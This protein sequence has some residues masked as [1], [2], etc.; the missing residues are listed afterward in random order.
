VWWTGLAKKL[1]K[2]AARA[3]DRAERIVIPSIAIF[4]AVD[5]AERGRMELS[6]PSRIW[7]SAALMRERVE[8][9]TLSTEIAIDAAQL[10]MVGDPFDRV[11]YAT[12]RA[13]DAQLVTMDERIRAFDPART[14]W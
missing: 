3:I 10:R 9:A 2:P 14:V 1:S 4:E 11:I 6:P 8:V 12:A 5:L 7:V 13:N